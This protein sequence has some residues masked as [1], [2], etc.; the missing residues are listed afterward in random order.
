MNK[1]I[2][3]A[4]NAQINRE[5]YSA[6]LYLSMSAWA[7]SKDFP[8]FA[9]WFRVQWKEELDHAQK[10]MT[11]IYRRG[12]VVELEKIEKP[13][14]KWDSLLIAFEDTLAHEKEVTA[15]IN[16]LVTLA[17]AEKDYAFESELKWFVDEQVEEEQNDM[18]IISKL[19]ML[20]SCS[21]EYFYTLDKEM[22]MRVYRPI[23]TTIA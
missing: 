11:F 13:P 3:T 2:N 18:Q 19:K 15:H 22:G 12:G 5:F 1:K 8:G 9:N 4:I 6:Y 14:V 16:D 7:E 17:R 20:G 23:P 10:F 21:G